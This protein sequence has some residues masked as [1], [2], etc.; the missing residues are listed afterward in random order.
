MERNIE[1]LKDV[2]N[3]RKYDD[4]TSPTLY[5]TGMAE[6]M[7]YDAAVPIGDKVLI[8]SICDKYYYDCYNMKISKYMLYL[9]EGPKN[10]LLTER[11]LKMI[12]KE[13][14]PLFSYAYDIA[15]KAYEKYDS[16]QKA[17]K[18]LLL[19]VDDPK[20]WKS[21]YHG[22]YTFRAFDDYIFEFFVTTSITTNYFDYACGN[23]YYIK[24]SPSDMLSGIVDRHSLIPPEHTVT[25]SEV[26]E[27]VKDFLKEQYKIKE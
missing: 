10:E 6:K 23:S 24:V 12:C 14:E 5:L 27:A 21:K 9:N 17:Y 20:C 8:F 25:F 7:L 15:K 3:W 2:E 4:K 19:M 16:E 13:V 22:L 11:N 1:D 18:E 26:R